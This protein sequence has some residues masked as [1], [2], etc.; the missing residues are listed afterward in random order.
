LIMAAVSEVE[1]RPS[2]LKPLSP[3]DV[4]QDTKPRRGFAVPGTANYCDLDFTSFRVWDE[5]NP[6]HVI[7]EYARPRGQVLPPA[8]E[9]PNNAR[10]IRYVF[11]S[12]FFKIPRIACK[13]TF[14]LGNLGAGSDGKIQKLAPLRMIERHYLDDKLLRS[15][16]FTFGP[17]ETPSLR[18]TW[19]FTYDMPPLSTAEVDE[20]VDNPYAMSSDS[21][22]FL[23]DELIL[24]HKAFYAFSKSS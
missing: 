22:Y 19:E 11:D 10:V 23:G 20:M 2:P 5:S 21:F 12:S 6:S 14:N 7:F 15:F 4:L 13:T 3:E 9:R 24:H 18:N 16:D 1:V 17:V 8:H